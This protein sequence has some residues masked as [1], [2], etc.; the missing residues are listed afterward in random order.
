MDSVDN[1]LE[2]TGRALQILDRIKRRSKRKDDTLQQLLKNPPK[3]LSD[4][5]CTIRKNG[6]G[7]YQGGEGVRLMILN[8]KD[9][10]VKI[11]S[12]VGDSNL[13]ITGITSSETLTLENKTFLECG[14]LWISRGK[15]W[16]RGGNSNIDIFRLK[17]LSWN[18]MMKLVQNAYGISDLFGEDEVTTLDDLK[19]AICMINKKC[20]M[21]DSC[22]HVSFCMK[23]A[24]K[25]F[26]SFD[27]DCPICREKMKKEIVRVYF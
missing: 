16:Y 21:I 22:R 11:N 7:V 25:L 2:G 9:C 5:S 18:Q 10:S 12:G 6:T 8:P 1:A 27:N 4:L 24:R 26:F 3:E 23:C 15:L 20:C 19:C 13:L 17:Q 14:G